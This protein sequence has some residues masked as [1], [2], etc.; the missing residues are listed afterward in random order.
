M[1]TDLRIAFR[2]LFK[3]PGFTAI[4]VVT[5]ALGIGACTALFSVIDVVLLRP[6]AYP[7]SER[8]VTLWSLNTQRGSRYQVSGPDFRDWHAGSRSFSA[9]AK[10]YLDEQAVVANGQAEKVG[11]ASISED[12]LPAMNIALRDG[13]SFTVA[14]WRQGGAVLVSTEFARHFFPDRESVLGAPV[15]IY[16]HTFPIVGVL[17]PGFDFPEHAGVWLPIDTAYPE[18]TERSAHNYRVLGRLAPGVTLAQAQSELSGIAQRLEQAYPASNTHAGAAVIRLQDYLVRNHRVTLWV[19]FA[20]VGV[21]LLIAC[22]NVANLLLARGTGRAR[23]VALRA[24]LGASSG[25]I[26]RGLLAECVVLS[27]LSGLAGLFLAAAGVRV[28]VTL[29]PAGI[30]RLDQAGLDFRALLFAAAV[31]ALVCLLA[32]LAPALQSARIDLRSA[33][34]VAGRGST[35]AASR[36]RSSLVVAQVGLSLV[37]L[38]GAGLLLRSFQLLSAV[39]PGYRAAQVLVMDAV[40]PASD[41]AGARQGTAFF[42]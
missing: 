12:F 14:E 3:T 4:T 25:R 36:L 10:Y 15:K 21:L 30:P 13:R 32:G 8:I 5:L 27:G 42:T 26:V 34:G 7:E 17:P 35:G 40:Y 23:E 16:G 37:L 24:A 38:T 22:T 31:V 33:L 11:V 2:Q 29:A 1:L 19:M 41:E 28:L 39:D 6:L 9:M 18:S 20:A